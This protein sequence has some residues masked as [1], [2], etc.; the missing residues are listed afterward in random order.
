VARVTKYNPALE[1]IVSGQS[2]L[3]TTLL[4]G[5]SMAMWQQPPRLTH[6]DAGS[7]YLMKVYEKGERH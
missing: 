1:H 2:I 5:S 3:P 7:W 4:E 6:N